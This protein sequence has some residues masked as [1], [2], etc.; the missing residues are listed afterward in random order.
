MTGEPETDEEVADQPPALVLYAVYATLLVVLVGT[1][2][3][4]AI[5]V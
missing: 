5:Y 1:L 4:A 2:I 3:A